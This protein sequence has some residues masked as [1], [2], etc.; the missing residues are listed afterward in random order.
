M[1][2]NFPAAV[3]DFVLKPYYLMSRWLL[4]LKDKATAGQLIRKVGDEPAE[5]AGNDTGDGIDWDLEL[6]KAVEEAKKLTDNNEFGMLNDYY[7]TYIGRKLNL[8]KDKDKS[9]SYSV[10]KEYGDLNCCRSVQDRG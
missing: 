6:E 4:D 9:L 1:E 2:D 5:P 8:Q 10:S 3:K 7:S